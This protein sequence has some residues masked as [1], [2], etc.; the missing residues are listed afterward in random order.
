MPNFVKLYGSILDST[1]WL[2][3]LP[4]KVVW[5]TML[6]MA[7][8][9]GCVVSS[10]PSLAKRAGVAREDCLTA[11][12]TL[13]APDPDSK[14]SD[15]EGRRIERVDGGWLIL[16]HRKYRDMRT[17]TQIAT[18][19]RVRKYRERNK[20]GV[21]VTN[22]TQANAKKRA[23]RT[24]AEAYTEEEAD[25][26][27]KTTTS[28]AK[29]K[30]STWVTEGASWWSANVGVI[31][32]PRFGKGLKDAVVT[33]GWPKVFSAL[34]EYAKD[35]KHKGKPAKLEWFASELIRW[36]EWASMPATDNNGDLTPRGRA[37]VE[38]R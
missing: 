19:E 31:A 38:G 33:H 2:E 18:A 5:I 6:A 24:E 13:A 30:T 11:L 8:A 1:I 20:Q 4:T 22:V 29:P 7:D 36:I 14:T 32:E 10:I 27:T 23:V 25:T 37:I 12:A 9:D 26:T 15:H 28:S 3:P 35:A 17:D 34:K 21:T 16:N